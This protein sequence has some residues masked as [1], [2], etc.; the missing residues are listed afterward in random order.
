MDQGSAMPVSFG[1]TGP[2]KVKV[3]LVANFWL[4]SSVFLFDLFTATGQPVYAILL[5]T[6]FPGMTAVGHKADEG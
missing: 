2:N 6:Y 4:T 1:T 3:E 5:L